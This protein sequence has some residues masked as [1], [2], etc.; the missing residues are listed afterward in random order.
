MSDPS[1]DTEAARAERDMARSRMK[2]RFSSLKG[3]YAQKG[4]GARLGDQVSAKVSD[5]AAGAVEVARDS[6]GVIAGSAGLLGLWLA[7]RPIAK[8]GGRL[9]AKAKARMD[10]GF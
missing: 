4:F 7:R 1:A 5:V 3:G 10:K 2:Q 9:W 8:L 6:K